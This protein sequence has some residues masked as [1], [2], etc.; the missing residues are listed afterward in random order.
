LCAQKASSNEESE[1][2]AVQSRFRRR[3]DKINQITGQSVVS[4]A[5]I[6]RSRRR[7][8]EEPGARHDKS[9]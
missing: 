6:A 1:Y 9:N 4:G 3:E 5:Q 2:L 8:L 7:D